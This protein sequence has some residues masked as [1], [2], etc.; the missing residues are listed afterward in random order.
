MVIFFE[1]KLRTGSKM[2]MGRRKKRRGKGGENEF[3]AVETNRPNL[4]SRFS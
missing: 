2:E 3:K 1:N 4:L